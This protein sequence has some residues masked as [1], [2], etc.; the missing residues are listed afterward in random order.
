MNRKGETLRLGT[1]RDNAVNDGDTLFVPWLIIVETPEG[2]LRDMHVLPESTNFSSVAN[3]LRDL[4]GPIVLVD[5][6]D[7]TL[8][9]S[10]SLRDGGVRDGDT[11]YVA[12][13]ITVKTELGMRIELHVRPGTLVS[14]VI[15]E[16]GRRTGG[17]C[18]PLP[19]IRK[20]DAQHVCAFACLKQVPGRTDGYSMPFI[21]AWPAP[22]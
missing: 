3:S 18:V 15:Q 2:K 16:V 17:K 10:M 8:L 13:T 6:E 4:P 7:R 20:D 9:P 14:S 1:L 5:R 21:H 22:P 19:C 11:V 12:W